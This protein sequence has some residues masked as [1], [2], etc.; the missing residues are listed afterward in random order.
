M[1]ITNFGKTEISGNVGMVLT[2]FSTIVESLKRTLIS[3]VGMPH[4]KANEAIKHAFNLGLLDEEELDQV[5]EE[6]NLYNSDLEQRKKEVEQKLTD[7]FAALFEGI[8][9]ELK[10]GASK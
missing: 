1:I 6:I 2:D 9:N 3:K 7:A 10:G 5:K 8:A 4:E